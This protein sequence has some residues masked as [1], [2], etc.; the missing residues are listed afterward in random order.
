MGTIHQ[1]L[2][3]QGKQSAIE[4]GTVS[5]D[6]IEA[7]A[8]Y[9]S[10]EDNALACAYSGWAQCALPHRRQPVEQ[11]WVV[12]SERMRLV[13]EPGRRPI[14]D[15]DNLEFVG[16]PFGSYARLILLYLQTQ[17]LRTNSREV[18]LGRSWRAWMSRIG[19]PWGGSSGK[20]VREQAELISRCRL[21]FHFQGDGR[22]GLVN[23][24]VVDGALFLEREG[25]SR[26]ERLSLETAKLSE[27]FFEAL[28]RHPIPLEEAAIKALAN[29]S[30]ALDC[31]IWLAYRLHSLSAPRLVTWK[32]LKAQHGSG[33]KELY[34]FKSKFPSVL[35]LALAVYPS[36]N[37]EVV[38]EGLILK[39]SRPPVAPKLIASR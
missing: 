9:L 32:A 30:A 24:S 1:L 15:S 7:A 17:A 38:E 11:A 31:Y 22:L 2:E 20:A 18:E 36:A 37:V 10:E 34:H 6:V 4:M 28:K 21:T 5:R 33:F 14:G 39:P 35:Q 23:Q 19:V 12:S 16:V 13:V 3:Q 25:V 27:G 26:Q 8:Q 29:N